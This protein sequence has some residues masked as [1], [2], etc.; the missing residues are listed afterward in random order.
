MKYLKCWKLRPEMECKLSEIIW[1]TKDGLDFLEEVFGNA[2]PRIYPHIGVFERC[3]EVR[4]DWE[5]EYDH[6]YVDLGDFCA[7]KNTYRIEL[8]IKLGRCLRYGINLVI[9]GID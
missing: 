9:V 4:T 3:K 5:L 6:T 8:V 2:V 7:Y 1:F